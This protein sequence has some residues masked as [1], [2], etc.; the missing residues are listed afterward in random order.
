VYKNLRKAG[1]AI[2][3]AWKNGRTF[4]NGYRASEEFPEY[5]DHF[6][7]FPMN[8]DAEMAAERLR[9]RGWSTRVELGADD[10]DWLL[11]ATQP[12]RGDEDMEEVFSEL[13]AF[14]EKF[15]GTYDGYGRPADDGDLLQ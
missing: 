8:S 14:A 4:E 11:W 2:E 10:T 7:Y 12:A 13:E 9:A 3:G 6:F 5:I 1:L 15:N